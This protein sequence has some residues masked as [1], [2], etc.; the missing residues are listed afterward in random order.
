MSLSVQCAQLDSVSS[1]FTT[2]GDYMNILHY[3]F[4]KVG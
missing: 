1:K 3:C 4:I 2:R